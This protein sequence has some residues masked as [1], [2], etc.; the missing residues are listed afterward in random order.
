MQDLHLSP[1]KFEWGYNAYGD[2]L[3]VFYRT[4]VEVSSIT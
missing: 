4:H 2:S 1:F 3:R